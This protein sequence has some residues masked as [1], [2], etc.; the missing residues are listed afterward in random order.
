M[1]PSVKSPKPKNKK[2]P[3][4]MDGIFL[5]WILPLHTVLAALL[6]PHVD[7]GQAS[8]GDF[9][10]IDGEGK[11]YPMVLQKKAYLQQG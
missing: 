11:F 8:A 9:I 1:P 5:R 7:R 4:H 6:A 10:K 3:V 2:N